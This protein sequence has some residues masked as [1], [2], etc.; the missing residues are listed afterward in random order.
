MYWMIV[1]TMA[2]WMVSKNMG[3][4]FGRVALTRSDGGGDEDGRYS[5]SAAPD[6]MLWA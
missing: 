5:C 2:Y 1:F 4:D 6:R 3:K